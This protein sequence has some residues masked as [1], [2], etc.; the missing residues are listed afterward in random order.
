MKWTQSR[1]VIVIGLLFACGGSAFAAGDG[2][3]FVIK[4]DFS[5]KEIYDVYENL[6]E[7]SQAQFITTDLALHTGHLLFDYSLRA[8]EIDKPIP[9]RTACIMQSPDSD[10][11]LTQPS[12]LCSGSHCPF[13]Q[14]CGIPY[15]CMDES[16]WHLRTNTCKEFLMFVLMDPAARRARD[17]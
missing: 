12:G 9:R 16:G 5:H 15:V 17:A 13:I 10:H 14:T 3:S 11:G 6:R 4:P 1:V 2:S 8:I 7:G